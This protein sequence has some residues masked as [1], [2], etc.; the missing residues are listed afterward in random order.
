MTTAMSARRLAALIGTGP[1]QPPAYESLA[2]TIAR[3]ITDGRI[4]AA[5]DARELGLVDTIGHIDDVIDIAR[6]R[7]GV[8]NARVIRYYRGGHAPATLSAGLA[9]VAPQAELGPA[10]SA[11]ERWLAHSTGPQPLYLWRGAELR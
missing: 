3:A 11:F 7:A 4:L 5:P 9:S 1:W 2:A 10:G 8:D 6:E